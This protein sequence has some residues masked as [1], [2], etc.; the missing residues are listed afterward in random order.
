M[1]NKGSWIDRLER[2]IGKYAIPDLMKYLSIMYII[3]L[4][5]CMTGIYDVVLSLDFNKIFHGQIWRLITFVVYPPQLITGSALSLIFAI[6]SISLYFMIGRSLENAWGTFRFNLYYFTG[7]AAC[8]LSGL[9]SYLVFGATGYIMTTDYVFQTMF[10]AFAVTFPDVELL[11]YFII[12]IKMKWLGWLEG[13]VMIF[14]FISHIRYAIMGSKYDIVGAI[15]M[16][17]CM[18]NF[19]VLVV[20]MRKGTHV[21]R[22]Q[23]KKSNEYKKK[24]NAS[25]RNKR[26]VSAFCGITD[27]DNPDMEFRY[28][29]RCDGNKEYCMEH[30]FTHEH[31][32]KIVINIDK[33]K[34]KEE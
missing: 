20:S 3:G 18:L 31:V 19:I 10:L 5:L 17:L 23:K 13:A 7:V 28:C 14:E 32:K 4:I 2:K 26:H 30:L 24:V 16:L 15:T 27:K 25:L 21:S 34:D 12:P 22:A 29:S 9:I 8:M 1:K 6:I 33:D 11:L